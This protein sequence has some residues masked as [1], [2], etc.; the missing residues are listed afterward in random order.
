MS[1]RVRDSA[2]LSDAYSLG[3]E[4]T[5]LYVEKGWKVIAAVRTPSSFP[6]MEGDVKVVKY[7]AGS[8]TDA[9]DVSF[10]L[11]LASFLFRLWHQSRK[12]SL[13]AGR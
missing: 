11:S 7:D 3:L 13:T 10:L 6:K 5:K 1:A 8:L 2:R 9:G 4:F 12:M